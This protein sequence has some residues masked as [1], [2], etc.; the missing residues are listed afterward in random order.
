MTTA[1]ADCRSVGTR[2][3][4]F[5][6]EMLYEAAVVA[7]GLRALP[8]HQVLAQPV[9]ARYLVGWGRPGDAG[10]IALAPDGQ[11]IGAAWYRL[12][13]AGER[14]VG[15][16]ALAGVPEV[17]IGVRAEYRRQGIG[18]MLLAELSRRACREGYRRLAVSVSPTDPAVHLYRRFGFHEVGLEVPSVRIALLMMAEL[19]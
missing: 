1:T 16:M 3:L 2:D 18:G 14:G 11:S 15:L 12:F 7:P 8:D 4:P 17:S 10:V 5:L 9:I 13:A 19:D 6:R